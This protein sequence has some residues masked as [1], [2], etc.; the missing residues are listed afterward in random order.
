[1]GVIPIFMYQPRTGKPD[2]DAKV[3]G[4]L[5]YLH[6]E[7]LRIRKN[8]STESGAAE[9]DVTQFSRSGVHGQANP[10]AP[11]LSQTS[12]PA[13]APTAAAEKKAGS[14]DCLWPAIVAAIL[15]KLFGLAGGRV[16]FGCCCWLKPKFGTCGAVD[17]SGVIGAV[18]APSAYWR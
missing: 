16:T 8:S 2:R 6:S 5:K 9:D 10:N 4:A 13:P 12:V 3:G 14:W 1:M 15:V 7:S 17:A 11:S 18:V